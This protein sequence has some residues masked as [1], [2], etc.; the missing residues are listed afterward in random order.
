MINYMIIML[1]INNINLQFLLLKKGSKLI[2]I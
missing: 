1:N 2:L